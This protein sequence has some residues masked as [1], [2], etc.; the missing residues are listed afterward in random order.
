MKTVN[1][2]N[3][4]FEKGEGLIPVVVQEIN[5]RNVLTLAYVNRDALELTIRTGWAHYYRRSHKRVMMKGA[6]SGNTQEIVKI[7]ADCDFDALVYMVKQKGSACHLGG[8]SC[9]KDLVILEHDS[10]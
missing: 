4:D 1:I 2:E 8:K 6:T 9:F 7:V 5:S 10:T 3:L